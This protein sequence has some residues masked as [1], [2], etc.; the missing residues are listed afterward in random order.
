MREVVAFLKEL[1]LFSSFHIS[2]LNELLASSQVKVFQPNEIIIK[3]GQ[4]GSFLGVVLSGEAEAAVT[5][6]VGN[7]HR[8]GLVKRGEFLGEIRSD[9]IASLS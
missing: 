6:P 4:P 1:P 5:G 2:E 9:D 3:F 7:Q 8:L